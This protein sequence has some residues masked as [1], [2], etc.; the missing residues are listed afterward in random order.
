MQGFIKQGILGMVLLVLQKCILR[1]FYLSNWPLRNQYKGLRM[2]ILDFG[3]ILEYLSIYR[4]LR[5]TRKIPEMCTV[6]H[7]MLMYVL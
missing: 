1:S 6:L 7:L 4:T 5:T 3:M 2:K